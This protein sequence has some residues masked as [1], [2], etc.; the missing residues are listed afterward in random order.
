MEK[1]PYRGSAALALKIS[2]Y[3]CKI[4]VQPYVSKWKVIRR[5]LC[6][7]VVNCMLRGFF[8]VRIA[9]CCWWWRWCSVL[10]KVVFRVTVMSQ[11]WWVGP[12][13]FFLQVSAAGGECWS[14]SQHY[15]RSKKSEVFSVTL[16]KK[17]S[18]VQILCLPQSLII[19]ALKRQ[20]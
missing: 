11:L 1:E 6:K 18:P 4:C 14:W 13:Y 16:F 19:I 8:I 5:L 17:P 15:Q 7:G 3:F 9:C 10:S 20:Q 2:G 12:L